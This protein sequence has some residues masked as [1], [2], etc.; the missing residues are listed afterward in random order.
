MVIIAFA[1]KSSKILP[2]IFCNHFKHCAVLLRDEKGFIMYQ[3][4]SHKNVAEIFI[5]TRDIRILGRYGWRFVYVPCDIDSL[6]NPYRAWTCVG[7][8]KRAIGMHAP[9][10]QTPDALYRKLC[11]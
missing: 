7:M 3:F 11:D 2:N 6:F 5:R 1:P 8:A 9:F 10:I 4:S